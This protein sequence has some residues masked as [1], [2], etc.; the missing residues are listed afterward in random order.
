MDMSDLFNEVWGELTAE[1]ETDK[2]EGKAEKYTLLLS[3]MAFVLAQK[4]KSYFN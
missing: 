3:R 4:A 2:A 1:K